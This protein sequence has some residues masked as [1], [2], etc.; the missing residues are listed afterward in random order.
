[1]GTECHPEIDSIKESPFRVPIP[2]ISDDGERCRNAIPLIAIHFTGRSASR[3]LQNNSSQKEQGV[4]VSSSGEE[5]EG[6]DALLS[7][8][9]TSKHD[10]GIL[11]H[12]LLDT[13]TD[14]MAAFALS[15]P[16]KE[17]QLNFLNVTDKLH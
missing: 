15:T 3:L 11:H 9:L 2:Y 16:P 6:T 13:Q 10:T 12:S 14:S 7:L 4:I 5:D 1:L 8:Y 17:A